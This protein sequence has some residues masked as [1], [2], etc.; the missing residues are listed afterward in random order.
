MKR[1]RRIG[2]VAVLALAAL[3][4]GTG[5]GFAATTTPSATPVA[6]HAFDTAPATATA[7]TRSF[8]GTLPAPTGPYA[9]GED[10][11]HLTD[12]SRPDPWVPSSGP[13]QLT[14]MM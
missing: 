12:A 2:A 6:T 13:R 4:A 11:I 10:V 5:A 8:Q 1:N 7:P 14:V 9:A 3:V